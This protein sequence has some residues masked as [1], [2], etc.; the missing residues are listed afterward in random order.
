VPSKS[1]A[2][3]KLIAFESNVGDPISVTASFDPA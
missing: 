3:L 1:T 2:G